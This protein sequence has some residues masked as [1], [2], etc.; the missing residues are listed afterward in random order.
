[1]AQSLTRRL[2]NRLLGPSS[3][4]PHP[5]V[6]LDATEKI[7][8]ALGVHAARYLNA[9]GAQD[10]TP[11]EMRVF[12]QSGE[13]G[14]IAEVLSRIGTTNRWFV[15]FGI[16]TGHQ[17]NCV[18]LADAYG[19]SGLFCEPDDKTFPKLQRKYL[20]NPNI[21]TDSEAI[22]PDNIEDVFDRHGVPLELDVLSIDVD[23][24]DY[25]IW[26]ALEKYRP[27]L[28][29]VEYNS[30]LS[31]HE[32]LVFPND[33]STRWDETRFY[34][35]SLGAF[36]QLA[37]E[38]HYQLVHTEMN[39]VNAFFVRDDLAAA[40]GVTSPPLRSMNFGLTGGQMPADPL[41]RSWINL[42]SPNSADP[43]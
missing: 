10:L 13:D 18:L 1:M 21:R 15:E 40:V 38:K 27:R 28:V 39:G 35:S 34:G 22:T 19:W 16:G 26:R 37:G 42:N 33:S 6:Y 41:N 29:V 30:S 43:Q 5:G 25:W 32:A 36:I 9:L 12:S 20:Y 14:V 8:P 3:P 11:F 4:P 17:G 7:Y 24:V 23:T 2:L 31:P